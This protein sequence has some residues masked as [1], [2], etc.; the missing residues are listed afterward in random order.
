MIWNIRIALTFT[1]PHPP[2]SISRFK[3]GTINNQN[4]GLRSLN[5]REKEANTFTF[6]IVGLE[7]FVQILRI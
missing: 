2:S 4:L 3:A 5:C 7:R 1:E 6:I